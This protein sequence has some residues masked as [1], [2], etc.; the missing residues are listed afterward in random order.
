[1][2]DILLNIVVLVGILGLS[3]VITS[4]FARAMYI[5]CTSCGTL[6]AKRRINCRT[7]QVVL[8]EV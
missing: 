5:R 3:A 4:A 1:M 2:K 8:R 6:N 7:C